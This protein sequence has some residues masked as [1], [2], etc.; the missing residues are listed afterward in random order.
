MADV[1][2]LVTVDS[3]TG[4]PKKL[5]LVGDAGEFMEVD[6]SNLSW[7]SGN[8]RGISIAVNI[9]TGDGGADKQAEMKIRDRGGFKFRASQPPPPKPQ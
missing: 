2:Y 8:A 6:L 9:Y 5:E 3:E 1:K 4:T 7:D